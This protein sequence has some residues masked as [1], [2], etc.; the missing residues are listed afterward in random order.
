MA[1]W[2]VTFSLDKHD[3]HHQFNLL[4]VPVKIQEEDSVPLQGGSVQVGQKK[5]V[6]GHLPEGCERGN[7]WQ[8]VFIPTYIHFVASCTDPWSVSDDN[9][10]KAML[11]IW[12]AI[13]VDSDG[14]YGGSI[15][16]VVEVNEAVFSIVRP[17]HR[18]SH[19]TNTAP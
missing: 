15:P 16:H 5:F 4:Q 11:N 8:R 9:A 14:K 13:F 18:V 17:L 1:E 3:H 12:D 7:Q 10:I 2:S 6:N 19:A